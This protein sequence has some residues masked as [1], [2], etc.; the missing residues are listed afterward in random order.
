MTTPVLT[1]ALTALR[2]GFDTAFPSRDRTTDGWIGDTAHSEH[3]S[4]HNPDDTAGSL[5]EYSDADTKPEVRAVD[6][7][8]DLNTP[9]VTMYDVIRAILATPADLN[10]LR[11][12][13]FCPPSGPLGADVP[14]EWS[15]SAGWKPVAYT[16]SSRH[17]HHAHFSGDPNT[18]EDGRPWQSVLGFT[19]E[20]ALKT[21]F[22][23]VT[24]DAKVWY[25]SP[26]GRVHVPDIT[27]L[28]AMRAAV[29]TSEV[30]VVPSVAVLNLVA[31]LPV[32]PVPAD[33]SA[34]LDA[35]LAAA[36]DDEDVTVQLGPEALAELTAVRDAV[37]AVA[38]QTADLVH[39]D[40]AD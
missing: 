4:G 26:L 36:N 20:E 35:I 7:D 28:A 19:R 18:D 29:G 12:I 15:R 30:A 39:A 37:A 21:P 38:Q 8:K 16:G 11:Y 9:G 17:D 1:V 40:L 10:R 2:S 14:T 6:V 24:G 3:V 27:T 22:F 25:L 5:A 31:P 13:I 32:V 23:Q 34:R 33:L